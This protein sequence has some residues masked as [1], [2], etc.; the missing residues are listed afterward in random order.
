MFA[1]SPRHIEA[2]VRRQQGRDPDPALRQQRHPRAVR[3]QLRP[4]AAAERQHHGIGAHVQ[5]TLWICKVQRSIV[6]PALPAMAHMEAHPGFAQAVQPGAQQRRSL[7]ILGKNP[8]RRTD[9][10]LDPQPVDPFA[11]GVGRKGFEQ[12]PD[13]IGTHAVARQEHSEWLGMGDVHAADA[14]QQELAAD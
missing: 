10:G 4:A 12:R 2:A 8:P 9:E 14:G 6:G 5:L 13:R 7:H 11:Q 1:P 3:P